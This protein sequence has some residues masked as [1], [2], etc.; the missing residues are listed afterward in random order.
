M[1]KNGLDSLKMADRALRWFVHVHICLSVANER[2][3]CCFIRCCLY[4][5]GTSLKNVKTEREKKV[6]ISECQWPQFIY[7]APTLDCCDTA[8]EYKRRSG[9]RGHQ[10]HEA[11]KHWDIQTVP[12]PNLQDCLHHYDMTNLSSVG[13]I[14]RRQ[15]PPVIWR[16]EG[17]LTSQ[18]KRGG[19]K[20]IRPVREEGT[21]L[22]HLSRGLSLCAFHFQVSKGCRQGAKLPKEGQL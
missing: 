1:E 5:P 11:R 7:G 18:E 8:G 6:K 4:H 14:R 3:I 19:I 15:K 22:C 9:S 16:R 2:L 17:R 20:K 10:R 13:T 12:S 21:R